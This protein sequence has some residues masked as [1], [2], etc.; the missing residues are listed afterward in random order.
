MGRQALHAYRLGFVHPKTGEK[1]QFE[2]PLPE[3]MKEIWKCLH[4]LVQGS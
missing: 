1:V 4:S 2:S 3:D